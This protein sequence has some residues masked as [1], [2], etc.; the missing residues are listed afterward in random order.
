MFECL[1]IISHVEVPLLFYL[2]FS[3]CDFTE[4][5]GAD[6]QSHRGIYTEGETIELHCKGTGYPTPKLEWV[7][8]GKELI[9]GGTISSVNGILTVTS[10][11]IEDAG[12]YKCIA[13]NEKGRAEDSTVVQIKLHSKY[14]LQI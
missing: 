10:A 8:E 5:I 1:L 2:W 4:T 7:K 6:I 3:I 9:S 13:F 14:M 11:T 12:M